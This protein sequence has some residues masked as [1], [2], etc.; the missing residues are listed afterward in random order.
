MA[1]VPQ[2]RCRG[3]ISRALEM[4]VRA[5]QRITLCRVRTSLL[6]PSTLLPSPQRPGPSEQN[7]QR[8]LG[9]D[10]PCRCC[11][12]LAGVSSASS[13]RRGTQERGKG[14]TGTSRSR[15][16]STSTSGRFT[17]VLPARLLLAGPGCCWSSL[18]SACS[19]SVSLD[20]LRST[21]KE[22]PQPPPNRSPPPALWPQGG[23][24]LERAVS[25][26]VQRR[27]RAG[28]SRLQLRVS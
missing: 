8:S 7:E 23:I 26:C 2:V 1:E 14:D 10:N 22:Q 16:R 4:V 3:C 20:Y 18:P 11:A 17:A 25:R 12:G 24:P 27:F 9:W 28:E 15:S 5:E 6:R 19:C 13:M 21:T